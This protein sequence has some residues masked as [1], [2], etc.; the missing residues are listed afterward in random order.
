MADIKDLGKISMM[1]VDQDTY[2]NLLEIAKTQG[3]SVGEVTSDALKSHIDRNKTL[4][5]SSQKKLLCEG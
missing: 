1:G 5:E 4:K 2:D 3:K